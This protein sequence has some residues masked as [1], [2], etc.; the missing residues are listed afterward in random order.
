[1][2]WARLWQETRAEAVNGA[3]PA[4]AQVHRRAHHLC[5]APHRAAGG[6][7]QLRTGLRSAGKSAVFGGVLLA[8]IEG[9]GILLTR[10]T[11]PPPAPGARHETLGLAAET[12]TFGQWRPP[13]RYDHLQLC[14]APPGSVPPRGSL[15][16]PASAC[17]RPVSPMVESIC[18]PAVHRC[19][20][21]LCPRM[22]CGIRQPTTLLPFLPCSAHG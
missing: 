22:T 19:R 2:C 20:T 16:H 6:F 14:I 3:C 1:M 10:V 4:R 5:P 11:A 17:P 21:T 18:S 9:V 15:C 7:L 12:A 13:L 8:M